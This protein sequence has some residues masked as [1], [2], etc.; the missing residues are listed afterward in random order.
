MAIKS[1]HPFLVGTQKILYPR[2]EEEEE[3][4]RVWK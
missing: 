4:T 1:P 3:A 2:T